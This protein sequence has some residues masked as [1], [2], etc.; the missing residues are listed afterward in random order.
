LELAEKHLGSI[1]RPDRKL[2]T[3]YTEEPPQDGERTVI[4]RR[5][6]SI[7]SI[8]AAYHMPAAA[9]PDWA[10][11]SILGSVLSEDKVGRLDK[12]LVET[13]IATSASGGADSSHDPGLFTFS[14]QPAEGKMAEAEDVLLDVIERLEATPFTQEEIDRAKLRAKRGYENSIANAATMSQALSSASALGDWR[15]WFLQR[16]R[17]ASVTV[18]DVNRV[19]ATYFKVHNRSKPRE[20]RQPHAH[21]QNWQPRS[22]VAPQKESWGNRLIDAQPPLW[23]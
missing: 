2:N 23:K 6:G 17:L 7:G 13:G 20:Y 21:G 1:P 8:I 9:H 5:V 3:T 4:L 10:P 15:L 16:D 12:A 22:C 18:E 11:L 14:V 19:A